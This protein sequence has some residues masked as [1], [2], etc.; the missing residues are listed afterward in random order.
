MQKQVQHDVLLLL[1]LSLTIAWCAQ[2]LGGVPTQKIALIFHFFWLI[3][4]IL[5]SSHKI[6]AVVWV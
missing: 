1:A 2:K 5:T 4:K 6:L 3:Q